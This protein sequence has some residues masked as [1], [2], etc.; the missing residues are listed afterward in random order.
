M[1]AW[2]IARAGGMVAYA[3]LSAAVI[4]GLTLSGRTSSKRWPRFALEDVH[5]FL[6]LLTGTFIGV[7]VFGLLID[8]YIRFS[9]ADVVIPG[10]ASYRPLWTALGIVSAELLGALAITN[11]YRKRIPHSVWKQAH[12]L[13][14]A[15]W[16]LALFHG[17]F[18]GTD[19]GSAWA[20]GLYTVSAATVGALTYIRLG[21]MRDQAALRTSPPPTPR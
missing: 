6:G 4:V 21:G 20:V 11:H 7:H 13:N 18:A 14:F 3:L 2:Y 12:R 9:I 8:S 17:I 5:R 15:V 19:T 1:T 10:S 16:A